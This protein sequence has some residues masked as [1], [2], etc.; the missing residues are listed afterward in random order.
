[1]AM[2]PTKGQTWIRRFPIARASCTVLN[3]SLSAPQEVRPA[4]CYLAVLV[5]RNIQKTSYPR[6]VRDSR[7]RTFRLTSLLINYRASSYGS[8]CASLVV[9][10]LGRDD[11]NVPQGIRRSRVTKIPFGPGIT[12]RAR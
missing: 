12:R 5:P 4:D 7:A 10:F 2:A 11:P 9:E 6:I 1:M 8:A 3:L